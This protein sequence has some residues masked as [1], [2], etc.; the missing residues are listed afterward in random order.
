MGCRLAHIYELAA[1]ERKRCRESAEK[2]VHLEIG[3]VR[4]GKVLSMKP[5]LSDIKVKDK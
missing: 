4:N 1:S 2:E 3:G 5:A